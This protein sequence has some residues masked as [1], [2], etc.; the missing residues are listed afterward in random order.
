MSPRTLDVV[1]AVGI[2]LGALFG[3][4][5]TIVAQA[6]LRQTLWLLDGVGL[7]VATSL[8]TVKF[9]RKGQDCVAAGFLVYAIAESVLLSGTA[10]GLAGSVPSFGGGV[11]LWATSLLL[12]SIPKVFAR[13]IRLAGTL[14]AILFAVTAVRIF[15]GELLLP[16]STPLPFF[17]YPF[18]IITFSGW[19]WTLVR[20]DE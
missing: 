5:G 1:A 11:A 19:V 4:A 3:L 20:Q 16:I 15:R 13:W 14:A 17:A 18:L 9:F 12:T 7:V 10:A 2:A 8:L 6:S